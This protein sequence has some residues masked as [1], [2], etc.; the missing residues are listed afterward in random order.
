MEFKTIWNGREKMKTRV[1]NGIYTVF[2]TIWNYREN[3]FEN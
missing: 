2:E 3:F 1:V